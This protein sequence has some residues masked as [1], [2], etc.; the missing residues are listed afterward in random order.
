MLSTRTCSAQAIPAHV[1]HAGVQ[2]PP[3]PGPTDLA[4]ITLDN[5]EPRDR[6]NSIGLL[7]IADL[8]GAVDQLRLP[9]TPGQISAIA[10]T[11]KTRRFGAGADLNTFSVISEPATARLFLARGKELRN[12]VSLRSPK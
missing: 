3:Q 7:G 11:S 4:L 8:E 1:T 10:L 12:K 6:P 9:T 2:F 5:G